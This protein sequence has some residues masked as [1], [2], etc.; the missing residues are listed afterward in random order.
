MYELA[1]RTGLDNALRQDLELSSLLAAPLLGLRPDA[2]RQQASRARK[3]INSLAW[4]VLQQPTTFLSASRVSLEFFWCAPNCPENVSQ[5]D[6]QLTVCV[7][8]SVL[9]DILRGLTS[10][11]VARRYGWNEAAVEAM[12]SQLIT[13]NSEQARRIFPDKAA[14]RAAPILTVA[15][16]LSALGID[17]DRRKQTKYLALTDG[18]DGKV[19][20]AGLRRGLTSWERCYRGTYIALDK[21]Q[22][23]L[24]LLSLLKLCNTDPNVLRVCIQ[25][26]GASETPCDG[27]ELAPAAISAMPAPVNHN[28]K[29]LRSGIEQAFTAVFPLTPRVTLV[30]PNRN[31]PDAYLQWDSK[32]TAAAPG[33]AGGST[34]GLSAVMVCVRAYLIHKGI[35]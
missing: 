13:T 5:A 19:E 9:N 24:G 28:T 10:P 30:H 7:V 21:P 23:A 16:S 31:R 17:F 35:L 18:L 27:D 22:D 1:L 8:E 2:L 26:A 11:T 20:D 3:D 4:S 33:A 15:G 34:A 29:L 6:K 12:I 25:S 32:D 14:K